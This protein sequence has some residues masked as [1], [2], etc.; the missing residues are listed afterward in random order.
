MQRPSVSPPHPMRKLFWKT[1]L[2]LGFEKSNPYTSVYSGLKF[3]PDTFATGTEHNRVAELVFIGSFPVCDSRQ[4]RE[5]RSA[6]FKWMD[7]LKRNDSQNPIWPKWSNVRRS[8]FDECLGIRFE[9]MMWG[10][11][12]AASYVYLHSALKRHGET[13]FI[14]KN[15]L[16]QNLN[17]I[18]DTPSPINNFS[19]QEI[20]NLLGSEKELVINNYNGL[21]SDKKKA[22]SLFHKEILNVSNR[23]IYTRNARKTIEKKNNEQVL[24]LAKS[25]FSLS[26]NPK[27]SEVQTQ[28]DICCSKIQHILFDPA[29]WINSQR[30]NTYAINSVLG[31]LDQD[32]SS[33]RLDANRDLPLLFLRQ[34]DNPWKKYLESNSI[35]LYSVHPNSNQLKLNLDTFVS[36]GKKSFESLLTINNKGKPFPGVEE[37]SNA[38]VEESKNNIIPNKNIDSKKRTS[39]VINEIENDINLVNQRIEKLNTLKSKL[40]L[41]SKRKSQ[42]SV[43]SGVQEGISY[44]SVVSSVDS[45]SIHSEDFSY[46]YKKWISNQVFE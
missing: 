34:P 40:L 8:Y 29:E 25:G 14:K 44:E 24:A 19:E 31:I 3:L 1:V 41:L 38:V 23:R 43:E 26:Q 28:I 16:L 13:H 20:V 17:F 39:T 15:N 37:D 22:I 33:L 21:M 46:E 6:A 2:A 32:N 10:L 45:L 18:L 5:F 27:T 35:S 7:E 42:L 30:E 4:A 9:T 36:L 11:G 12:V